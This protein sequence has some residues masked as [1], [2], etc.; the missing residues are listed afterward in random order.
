MRQATR[1]RHDELVALLRD[2]VGEV[3]TLAARVGVSAS[4]V[5]R[6][7]T[8][9][10]GEGRIARTYGGALVPEMFRERSFSE[11]T[12]LHAE[13]KARIARAAVGLL[14]AGESV[15]VDAGTTCLALAK[16]LTG[17]RT[18]F[19]RGLESALALARTPEVE[20]VMLGGT[21]RPLSHGL[22]GPLSGLALHR[23]SFDV[24]VLGAD[25][26][27]PERG[28]G[29]PTADETWVKEQAAARARR[30]VIV[31]DSAKLGPAPV[32]A[33]LPLEPGWTLVTDAGAPRE[34]RERFEALG[35]AV[36]V[37]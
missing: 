25:A 2:G 28:L 10:A 33:W 20:T 32:P 21:V 12:E 18:V 34:V 19:T 15:F 9:L 17:P 29:E 13:E 11:S 31:A 35:V 36:V 8:F 6:D 4:T 14:G 16:L 23:I 27:D 1:R 37:A 7:L 24:A 30:V 3:E 22:V 26:V 5:R